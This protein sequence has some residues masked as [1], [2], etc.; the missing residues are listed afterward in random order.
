MLRNNQVMAADAVAMETE[1]ALAVVSVG[2]AAAA[3]RHGGVLVASVAELHALEK[4]GAPWPASALEMAADTLPRLAARPGAR[5]LTVR[6]LTKG[7]PY[8][9][10]WEVRHVPP[11]ARHAA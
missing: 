8:A 10:L 1:T 5:G 11:T 2:L 6:Q 9:R 3:D 4:G 7:R